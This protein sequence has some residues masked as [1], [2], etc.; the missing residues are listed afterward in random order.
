MTSGTYL[1]PTGPV[2]TGT[3][4]GGVSIYTTGPNMTVA[5]SA[6]RVIIDWTSFSIA[7]GDSVTFAEPDKDAI[8]VNREMSGT[9]YIDGFL[10]SLVGGK[11][12]GN[13]WVIDPNGIIF[14]P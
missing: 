12:G 7:A 9:S 14:G 8:V 4:G 5:S 6:H 1:L 11:V 10:T 2:I 3:S 13:V